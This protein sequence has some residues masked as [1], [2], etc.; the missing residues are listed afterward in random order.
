MTTQQRFD[1]VRGGSLIWALQQAWELPP[2][3]C[4]LTAL[5]W[6]SR[7]VGDYRRCVMM[8]LEA[9]CVRVALVASCL[10]RNA[11]V[12]P[13]GTF[14]SQPRVWGTILDTPDSDDM[15]LLFDLP[16]SDVVAALDARVRQLPFLKPYAAPACHPDSSIREGKCKICG[17]TDKASLLDDWAKFPEAYPDAHCAKHTFNHNEG[18]TFARPTQ[19]MFSR[20]WQ[21]CH[22]GGTGTTAEVE[23]KKR[24]TIEDALRRFGCR[25]DIHCLSCERTKPGCARFVHVVFVTVTEIIRSIKPFEQTG[26]ECLRDVVRHP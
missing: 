6:E 8:E 9:L 14:S 16:L 10:L 11:N 24:G 20:T 4:R 5:F 1:C 26:V 7:H 21:L 3:L 22:A 15:P 12:V 17:T 13:V 25:L 18:Q 19:L 23:A 2:E